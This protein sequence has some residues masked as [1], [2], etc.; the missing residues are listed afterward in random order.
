MDVSCRGG[1][2]PRK[3]QTY[4]DASLAPGDGRSRS[5]VLVS[6][7]DETINRASLILWQSRRQTLTAVSALEAEVVALSEA[8]APSAVIHDACLDI[9]YC[10]C[11]A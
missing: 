2:S 5:G 10:G 4:C 11:D 8:L 6:M 1:S 3:I 9:R 7:V